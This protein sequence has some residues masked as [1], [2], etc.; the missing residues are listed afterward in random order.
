LLINAAQFFLGRAGATFSETEL[1]LAGTLYSFVFSQLITGGFML[2]LSRYLSDQ[3]YSQKYENILSSLYGVIAVCF[4]LG[5]LA[6]ILFYLLSPL[7][8][9]FKFISYL[10]FMELISKLESE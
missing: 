1:F 3:L 4:L 5:G 8:F 9:L 2:L 6:G 10:F 7:D